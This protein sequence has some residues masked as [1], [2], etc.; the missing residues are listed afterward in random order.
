MKFLAL[1]ILATLSVS[2]FAGI[3]GYATTSCASASGRTYSTWTYGEEASNVV[4]VQDG[5]VINYV[6]GSN[7]VAVIET[8]AGY[9]VQKNGVEQ[10][11][12]TGSLARR[13]LTV[14]VDARIGTLAA[15]NAR[16]AAQDISVNCKT[17][18]QQ[19]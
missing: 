18:V 5:Q 2:A 14:S 11:R 6:V 7:G 12:V 1:A 17:F 3:G 16:T 19:P 10:L 13:V 15:Q 8:D 4:L 9:I